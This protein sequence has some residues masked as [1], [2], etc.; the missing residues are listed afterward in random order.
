MDANFLI[1]CWLE[2]SETGELTTLQDFQRGGGGESK[3][4]CA[5]IARQLMRISQRLDPYSWNQTNGTKKINGVMNGVTGHRGYNTKE[6][7]ERFQETL[8]QDLLKQFDASYRKQN[9]D[10]MMEC[11]KVLHDFNGGQVLLLYL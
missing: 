11:A 1:Q 8:E 5:I 10:D 4:R 3:V 7:I 9:F 2:V 6:L